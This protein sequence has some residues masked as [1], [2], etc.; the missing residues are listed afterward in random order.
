MLGIILK[1]DTDAT[2]FTAMTPM[3]RQPR[4]RHATMNSLAKTIAGLHALAVLLAM[5]GLPAQD[6]GPA[7]ILQGED[8]A[9]RYSSLRFPVAGFDKEKMDDFLDEIRITLKNHEFP[10]NDTVLTVD[11]EVYDITRKFT[12]SGKDVPFLALFAA[13]CEQYGIEM[14]ISKSGIHIHAAKA[15][16]KTEAGMP[17]KTK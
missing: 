7:V 10:K 3:I 14:R 12:Y 11:P 15:P 4:A 5:S 16:G 2:T 17:D 13:A 9:R 8:V 1:F 6:L